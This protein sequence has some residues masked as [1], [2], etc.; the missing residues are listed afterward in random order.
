MEAEILALMSSHPAKSKLQGAMGEVMT[1]NSLPAQRRRQE[2][3]EEATMTPTPQETPVTH[4]EVM[5]EAILMNT[6]PA[7]R[8]PQEAMEEAMTTSSLP[9]Q[10]RRQEVMEEATMT[11]TPQETPATHQ[12]VMEA[13]AT[14][15]LMAQATPKASPAGLETAPP[16][17]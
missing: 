15:T 9:A 7:Q 13:A 14:T 3:M 5:E 1:T 12:E 17:S 2:V 6:L 8:R 4:Q 10:R 11:P 16:A